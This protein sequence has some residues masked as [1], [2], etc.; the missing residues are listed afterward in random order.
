MQGEYWA[1]AG[2]PVHVNIGGYD[3]L[4]IFTHYC[5]VNFGLGYNKHSPSDHRWH[6][7]GC[8]SNAECA[9][10]NTDAMEF[11]FFFK[12]KKDKI[13]FENKCQSLMRYTL[14]D[15]IADGKVTMMAKSGPYK[16]G[17]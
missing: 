1:N 10:P 17:N 7:L 15:A 16:L 13:K 14:A 12:F 11:T 2:F 9:N 6:V 5:E 8:V 3:Q 4:K